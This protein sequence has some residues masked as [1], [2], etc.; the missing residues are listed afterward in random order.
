[1]FKIEA[2]DHVALAVRDVERSDLWYA[3]VHGFKRLHV[4]IWNGVPI[5]V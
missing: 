5:I 3:D 2:L 4:V 1:M